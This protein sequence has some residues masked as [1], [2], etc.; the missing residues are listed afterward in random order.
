MNPQKFLTCATGHT[1]IHFK[2][3]S[4]TFQSSVGIEGFTHLHYDQVGHG[5]RILVSIQDLM[6]VL[7]EK[8]L[9]QHYI[10]EWLQQVQQQ[11]QLIK[12]TF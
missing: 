6:L 4:F 12:W 10:P 2:N 3:C 1:N 7:L 8:L 11:K 5:S 9:N